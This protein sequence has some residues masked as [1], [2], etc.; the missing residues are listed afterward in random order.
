MRGLGKREGLSWMKTAVMEMGVRGDGVLV[1][2]EGG[3]GEETLE[4]V[5]DA[6]A[7]AEAFLDGGAEVGEGFQLATIWGGCR[8]GTLVGR[9]RIGGCGGW[10]GWR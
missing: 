6:V 9:A 10:R 5:G 1:V 8:F 4:A 3:V 2:L 7:D